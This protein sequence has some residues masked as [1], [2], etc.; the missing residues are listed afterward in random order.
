MKGKMDEDE[1]REKKRKK[2][3]CGGEVEVEEKVK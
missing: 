3:K 2:R 1:N